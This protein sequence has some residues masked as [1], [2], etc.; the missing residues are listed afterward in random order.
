MKPL[1]S[2]STLPTVRS[3]PPGGS[4]HL[5]GPVRSLEKLGKWSLLQVPQLLMLL[6]WKLK[7][8]VLLSPW[9]A[10]DRKLRLGQG[11]LTW[12]SAAGT[13]GPLEEKGEGFVLVTAGH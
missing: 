2:R 6:G 7:R 11:Q 1:L 9:E 12:E 8:L 3:P 4:Y 5:W 13:S 10:Q